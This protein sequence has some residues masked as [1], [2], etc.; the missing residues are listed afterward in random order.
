MGLM[1]LCI[2]FCFFVIFVCFYFICH[3]TMSVT[4]R[5][6]LHIHIYISHLSMM[7]YIT[8]CGGLL[9]DWKC[10]L[11]KFLS[12][13]SIFFYYKLITHL[14]FWPILNCK[15]WAN[16]C[17][18]CGITLDKCVLSLNVYIYEWRSFVW[19]WEVGGFWCRLCAF[20]H[21]C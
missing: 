14:S 10:H 4:E 17:L 16:I 3:K 20:I 9:D 1:Y 7:L 5:I 8:E 11:T 2:L 18:M 6:L 21:Y 19:Q 15:H 13:K 12:T